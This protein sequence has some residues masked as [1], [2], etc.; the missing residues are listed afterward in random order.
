MAVVLLTAGTAQGERTVSPVTVTIS[1]SG[2]GAVL[3]STSSDACRG[4]CKFTLLAGQTLTLTAA[5]DT[6]NHFDAWS[7][8]CVGAGLKC[9]LVATESVTVGAAFQSGKQTLPPLYRLAV[10]VSGNGK[11]VSDPPGTIDCANVC[12]IKLSSN[13]SVTLNA[14]KGANSTFVGWNG[15]CT[16]TG[17]CVVKMSAVQAAI[18]VF[19][20][21]PIPSGTSLVTLVNTNPTPPN[22]PSFIG[23]GVVRIT[24]P[25]GTSTC[26]TASCTLTVANGSTVTFEALGSGPIWKT[27]CIGYAS[28]CPIVVSR[29]VTVTVSFST[30]TVA[31]SQYGVSVAR[32]PGGQITSVPSGIKCG[33]TGGCVAA[34]SEDTT[35][36]LTA[37]ADPGYWF[38]GWGGDCSGTGAC[39]V[40]M[41][42]TRP[43]IARFGRCAA[44]AV[45][46]FDISVTRRPRRVT[47]GL[48]LAGTAD[49]SVRL[50]KGVQTIGSPVRRNAAVGPTTLQL[51]VPARAPRAPYAL[52]RVEVK[53]LDACGT[54]RTL[55]RP[56]NV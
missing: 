19:A 20:E 14:V 50:R 41:D 40:V 32:T 2:A 28:I 46:S 31:N 26:L 55:T 21:T 11:V 51:N 24:G 10:T 43:V 18:A 7:G 36:Q 47:V 37:T 53:L 38:Q 35:V 29:P 49:L 54:A 45:S 13:T 44:S 56:V 34:F 5:P 16:G 23:M 15:S 25:A 17:D 6:D 12:S 4:T 22:F 42:A 52:Y 9:D 27:G 1:T 3:A 48:K 39:S 33:D 30:M 8:A